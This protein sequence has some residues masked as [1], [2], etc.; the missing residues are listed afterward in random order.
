[1][2]V[3]TGG[4]P[5]GTAYVIVRAITS[6]LPKDISRGIREAA[7]KGRKEN[8]ATGEMI[9]DDI[10]EGIER[11]TS[12]SIGTSIN[13]RIID[14]LKKNRGD[15]T[16]EAELTGKLVSESVADGVQKDSD[17][18]NRTIL[19]TFN[20]V[21]KDINKKI[22]DGMQASRSD[23]TEAG[24]GAGVAVSK[25]IAEG[26]AADAS[27][28]DRGILDSFKSLFKK[29][30]DESQK[31]N[32][33]S[34]IVDSVGGALDQLAKFRL[35]GLFWIGVLAV[36]ALGGALSMIT[37]YLGA[38]PAL[39]GAIGPGI[40]AS[41]SIGLTA[42]SSLMIGF[43]S[44]GF[45]LASDQEALKDFAEF[46]APIKQELTEGIAETFFDR[47]KDTLTTLEPLFPII[48]DYLTDITGVLS[49][50]LDGFAT[51]LVTP[52]NQKLL[53]D[54]LEGV[55]TNFGL[56]LPIVQDLLLAFM[57]F[58]VAI[59]PYTEEFLLWIGDLAE[60]LK[61]LAIEGRLSGDTFDW[62]GG[63][64][65]VAKQLGDIIGALSGGL[66]GLFQASAPAGQTLLDNMLTLFQRFDDFTNSPEGQNKI[67]TFMENAL[68]VISEVNALIGAIFKSL[69]A[70][71]MD[72]TGGIVDTLRMM[73][74]ELLP[75]IVMMAD[76]LAPLA[77]KMVELLSSAVGLIGDLAESGALGT[78]VDTLVVII[79]TIADL[80]AMPFVGEIV[81]WTI[82]MGGILSAISLFAKPLK[83]LLA[84]FGML[85]KLFSKNGKETSLFIRILGGFK[86]VLTTVGNGF[87]F[88]GVHLGKFASLLGR[89]FM[90][91]MRALSSMLRA[92]ERGVVRLATTIGRG[93]L[94]AI[95]TLGRLFVSAA[96]AVGRFAATVG[97]G[98]LSVMSKMGTILRS[99]AARVLPLLMQG[100]RALWV[101][102]A[103]NPIGAII[104]AISLLV[105]A[106]IWL[107]N[108]N[109]TA[110]RIIDAAWKG[111]RAAVS[112]VVNWFRD[113]V[114]PWMRGVLENIGGA[115]TWLWENAIV[116]AWNGI[117]AVVRGVVNWFRNTA[118]P[119]MQGVFENIGAAA[120]W[121]YENVITPA[122]DGIRTAIRI[123]VDWM[124]NT[125]WPWI[126][127]VLE[128][129]GNAFDWLWRNVIIPV[130]DGIE[131]AIQ[132][133]WDAVETIFGHFRRGLGNLQDRFR[134]V[135]QGIATIWAAIV[136]IVARP[137]NIMIGFVN[138][139]FIAGL[140]WVFD[141][142][143][144][145]PGVDLSWNIPKIPIVAIP[146]VPISSGGGGGG[147]AGGV[148]ALAD[149]GVVPGYSPHA[150]ADNI[151]ARL[152]AGEFVL[153]VEATKRLM[154]ALGA[155]GMEFLRRG[156]LPGLPQFA[157][158][159]PV[160][161]KR[162]GG[163]LGDVWDA[164]AGVGKDLV[165]I[166]KDPVKW[167]TG[168]V[169]GYLE[170][171]KSGSGLWGGAGFEA[172]KG[173]G[174]KLADWLKEKVG[175]GAEAVG[176]IPPGGMQWPGI[177]AIIKALNPFA[178]M[179]SNKRA[180]GGR[181]ASGALSYHG[182]GRAVD[183]VSPNMGASWDI[184]RRMLPWSELYYTPRGFI[185]RG[186]LVPSSAV[187]AITKK[188]HYDHVHAAFASGGLV[189]PIGAASI[190]KPLLFD[191]GG[192]LPTGT[193]VVR[194]NTGKPEPLAR[195]GP[196]GEITV[197]LSDADRKLLSQP[198]QVEFV[199]AA[200]AVRR[201]EAQ[202]G[203]SKNWNGPAFGS[204]TD[205]RRR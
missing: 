198:P 166:F 27:K 191:R 153:P 102:M 66:F 87:K 83:L 23:I 53:T 204:R 136:R 103:A 10:S 5:V 78:F 174:G 144:K 157:D 70:G 11:K 105:G 35:P 24:K 151:L 159:G 185:R 178:I 58:F 131:T 31:A 21:G 72:G 52:A 133:T 117:Q 173:I 90:T 56:M 132:N 85:I 197:R 108:N 43:M 152:T 42:L 125:A 154:K 68:P 116:P 182:L 196:N 200:R 126:D 86:R 48:H 2:S 134:T 186:S 162:T 30:N 107:Y 59:Q 3:P 145:I 163:G 183:F 160:L 155:Q 202:L 193:S 19:E 199:K 47:L 76:Q 8:I 115:A 44:L 64:V 100:L 97:R 60:N 147:G 98:F 65:E 113:T 17:R 13:R 175:L 26:V 94:S 37:A 39:I 118:W 74:E 69:G 123:V 25:S 156:R 110:K 188:N 33:G 149:G 172:L 148:V 6:R 101:L 124:R 45:V 92:V 49:D 181:T 80:L 111:I 203:P 67:A 106:L 167:I 50:F 135:R 99:V 130:W 40:A 12:P 127:G 9:G 41:A 121:L 57:N 139:S 169:S 96:S 34:R 18:R 16:D 201:G 129:M 187:S 141:Q 82:A 32:L 128:D 176:R 137:I 142:I 158:G 189:K 62:M 51:E 20:D 79:G 73:R 88:V 46:L 109:D 38:I 1:M 177:W 171:I 120:N 195:L 164:I 36:P 122:W 28:R 114:W 54:F 140:N 150:R 180:T 143:D 184:L 190:T 29:I 22:T 165:E 95:Q 161:A 61:E 91:S 55:S 192:V 104:T 93:L 89:G 75:A 205:P 14:G 138:D 71:V 84:P 81:A 146:S 168:K 15:V 63:A 194:N 119:W 7:E 112:V 179:T 170:G 4:G 77:P